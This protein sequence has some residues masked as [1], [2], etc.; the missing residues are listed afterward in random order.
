MSIYKEGGS[1]SRNDR[2]EA[3]LR[4]WE[5]FRDAVKDAA[6]L[7]G[8]VSV[9]EGVSLSLSDAAS[10]WHKSPRSGHVFCPVHGGVNGDAFRLWDD[11]DETGGCM[12]NTC[13]AQPDGFATLMFVEGWNFNRT[14]QEVATYLG[15]W[16]DYESG[17]KDFKSQQ[18]DPVMLAKREAAAKQREAEQAEQD[19]RASAALARTWE[20]SIPAS[21]SDV[22]MQYLRNRGIGRV[23]LDPR[24]FRFVED[25]EYYVKGDDKRPVLFGKFP[26]LL[27]VLSDAHGNPVT[28]HRTYLASNGQKAPVDKAKKLMTVPSELAKT[29]NAIRM[30]PPGRVMGVSEGIETAWSAW[31]A[32]NIPTWPTYSAD[33]LANFEPPVGVEM[34]LAWVDNDRSGKG[35]E[36]GKKLKQRMWERGIQTCIMMPDMEIPEGAS[37]V[38]WNDVLKRDGIR[39]F[40]LP[41]Q[42]RKLRQV[43]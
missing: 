6:S 2:R 39:A 4:R 10:A 18:P 21:D 7:N 14:L 22:V 26:C 40:P 19:K 32:S 38:D 29:G 30:T 24:V 8:W 23:N 1:M 28:L 5:D 9:L 35:L 3:G 16:N 11:A 31:Y 13:G 34:I 27:S 17:K 20:R 36:S 12:C 37:G 33:N 43:A 42:V 41:S 25:M 15:M